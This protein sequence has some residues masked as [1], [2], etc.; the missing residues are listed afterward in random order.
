MPE[1]RPNGVAL[2]LTVTK[3]SLCPPSFIATSLYLVERM[4]ILDS[5]L[6]CTIADITTRPA[7][8]YCPGDYYR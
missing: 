1:P 3:T 2:R 7:I 8:K 4:L 5:L 6:V